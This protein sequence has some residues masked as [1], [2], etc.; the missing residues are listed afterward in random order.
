MERLRRPDAIAA[1]AGGVLRIADSFAAQIVPQGGLGILYFV[2][3][4]PRDSSPH[5][6]P[7]TTLSIPNDT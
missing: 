2:T 6:P 1:I 4:V 5:T 7:S 3:D